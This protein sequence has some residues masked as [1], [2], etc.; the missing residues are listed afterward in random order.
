MSLPAAT[1][2]RPCVL[3]CGVLAWRLQP[4]HGRLFLIVFQ[5]LYR[6]N[7]GKVETFEK[8]LAAK[9]TVER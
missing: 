9:I 1:T 8:F 7:Y 6:E 5:H 3:C 2:A 4:V